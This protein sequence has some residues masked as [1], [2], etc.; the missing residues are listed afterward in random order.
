MIRKSEFHLLTLYSLIIPD[1]QHSDREFAKC[2]TIYDNNLITIKT[3][4][5]RSKGVSPSDR[6]LIYQCALRYTM[7]IVYWMDGGLALTQSDRV[8]L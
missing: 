4:Q 6:S 7:M 3:C 5:V 8:I 1:Q 2:T